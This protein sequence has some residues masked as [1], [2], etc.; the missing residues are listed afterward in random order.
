MAKYS[1]CICTRLCIA[2]VRKRN[3]IRLLNLLYI[4]KV[5]QIVQLQKIKI[6]FLASKQEQAYLVFA[7]RERILKITIQSLATK[8]WSVHYILNNIVLVYTTI[9]RSTLFS[10]DNISTTF[11]FYYVWH[12]GKEPAASFCNHFVVFFSCLFP[13]ISL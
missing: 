1:S 6:D 5:N 10:S 3:T 4:E 11:V 13:F 7:Y 2:N 9:Y 8:I 12:S